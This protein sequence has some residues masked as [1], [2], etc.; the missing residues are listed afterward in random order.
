[1]SSNIVVR[2][3]TDLR[4]DEIVRYT[5]KER[6]CHWIS[7]VSYLYLLLTGLALFTPYLYWIAYVLGG[8]PTI[9]FWHPW[10]G[11]I[12]FV[13]VLWMQSMWGNDMKTTKEDLE[14][15]KTVKAYVTNRDDQVAP[16]GHFNSGQKQFYWIMF[17]G[18]IILFLTGIVMWFPE[19]VPRS[20]HWVLPIV[21]FL[22]CVGALATIGAFIIHLYMGIFFVSGG[23]HG[24]LWGRVPVSWAQTHHRLWYDKML[25]ED[26]QSVRG[27]GA[28]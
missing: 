2:H 17:W 15:R 7:G 6:M 26:R 19:L 24:I 10:V 21:V 25:K 22:H 27:T 12:F 28:D 23:L 13:S 1:M 18:G 11:L 8:G 4:E 5:L 9:R 20:A 3:G 14:W 16:A